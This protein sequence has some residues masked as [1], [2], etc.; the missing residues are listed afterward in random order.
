NCGQ[1]ITEAAAFD[2]R[3]QHVQRAETKMPVT[4]QFGK[5]VPVCVKKLGKI[6]SQDFRTA[7][8]PYIV[9]QGKRPACHALLPPS[10]VSGLRTQ[11]SSFCL[12]S[13]SLSLITGSGS[14]SSAY[15][16][17]L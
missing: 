14:V 8:D 7:A 10:L 2:V 16:T 12:S 1:R 17:A 5:I 3:F 6:A 9:E 4:E 15:L 13:V 11:R